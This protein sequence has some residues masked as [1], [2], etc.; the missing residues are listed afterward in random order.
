MSTNEE[1]ESAVGWK[2]GPHREKVTAER[3]DLFRRAVA[4]KERPVAPPTFLTILRKGE[5]ELFQRMGVDLANVLHAE[6]EYQYDNRILPED[7]LIFQSEVVQVLGKSG[8]TGSLRFVTFESTVE[9]ER[10]RRR[11]ERISIG[12]S[13][14]TVVVR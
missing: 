11:K 2:S 3:I 5:F 6:Q 12:K 7:E 14:T 13:R 9:A 8:S 1:L 4:A 10:G